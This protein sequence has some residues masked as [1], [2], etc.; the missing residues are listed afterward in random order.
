MGSILTKGRFLFVIYPILCMS[1]AVFCNMWW[2]KSKT[3]IVLVLSIFVTLS[4]S[5]TASMMLNYNAPIG[6]YTNFYM[7]S[8]NDTSTPRN[9][10]VGKE[11]YRFPSSFFL[12]DNY[13]LLFLKSE[14]NGLLP[15]YFEKENGTSIVP[16][17]MNDKNEPILSRYSGRKESF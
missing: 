1:A 16:E 9:V 5:R 15:K 8:K 13:N 12:R 3:L 2:K 10:C 7:I 4:I 11:W 17:E 14:F 6:V